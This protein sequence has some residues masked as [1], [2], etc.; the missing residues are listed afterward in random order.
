MSTD[1]PMVLR[2][3]CV[4]E[5]G[6]LGFRTPERFPLKSYLTPSPSFSEP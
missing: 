1:G 5:V 6:K 2:V 4:A 3:G